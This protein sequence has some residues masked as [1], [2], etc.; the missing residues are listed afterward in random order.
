MLRSKKMKPVV[1][2]A[3]HREQK[4]AK[5]LVQSKES[6]TQLENKLQTL[7]QHRDAYTLNL[8]EKAKKGIKAADY[9]RS[10]SFL[11][12]IEEA[13]KQQQQLIRDS[14]ATFNDNKAH[15]RNAKVKQQVMENVESRLLNE[16]KQNRNKENQKET[17]DLTSLRFLNK[18]APL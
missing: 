17:D 4:S 9:S 8:H 7:M 1:K 13:I 10:Q 15:W 14:Q 18:K 5:V 11:S 3:G 12:Q 2:L 6:L 16:E